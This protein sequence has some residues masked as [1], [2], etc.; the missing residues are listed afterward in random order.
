[1]TFLYKKCNHAL[2]SEVDPSGTEQ[3]KSRSLKRRKFS[4]KDSNDIWHVDGLGK[5][6][7]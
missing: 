7:F 3:G 6:N 1:M 5:L 4:A 2:T